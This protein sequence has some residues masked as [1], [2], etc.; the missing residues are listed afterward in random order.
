[1]HFLRIIDITLYRYGILYRDPIPFQSRRETNLYRLRTVDFGKTVPP[2]V[3]HSRGYH[4]FP[5]VLWYTIPNWSCGKNWYPEEPMRFFFCIKASAANPY[6]S[7]CVCI[8]AA[9]A[10]EEEKGKG[11]KTKWFSTDHDTVYV[12]T[13]FLRKEVM[14]CSS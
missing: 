10:A 12:E 8:K 6:P 11:K 13:K 14:V 3:H 4:F 5:V 9:A 2:M 7:I 1:M